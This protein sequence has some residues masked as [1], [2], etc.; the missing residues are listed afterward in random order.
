MPQRRLC[1]FDFLRAAVGGAAHRRPGARQFVGVVA[2]VFGDHR[3]GLYRLACLVADAAGVLFGLKAEGFQRLIQPG[4]DGGNAAHH[5]L[6]QRVCLRFGQ[7]ARRFPSLIDA[8]NRRQRLR[9]IDFGKGVLQQS[10]HL[11][12]GHFSPF[13]DVFQ[14]VSNLFFAF[15]HLPVGLRDFGAERFVSI[16]ERFHLIACHPY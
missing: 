9:A 12:G 8:V 3:K 10:L 13:N 7:G 11:S 5:R 15:G 6:R 14:R 4:T 1:R 16:S 2:R